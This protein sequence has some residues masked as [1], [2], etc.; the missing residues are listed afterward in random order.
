M[1]GAQTDNPFRPGSGQ[2]PPVLG[3]RVGVLSVIEASFK[4]VASGRYGGANF[5]VAPA[6]MGKTALLSYAASQA[7]QLGW[8][9]LHVFLGSPPPSGT[10]LAEKAPSTL[11]ASRARSGRGAGN[12]IE[13]WFGRV[14]EMAAQRRAGALLTVDDLHG[15]VRGRR[16]A[17]IAPTLDVAAVEGWPLVVLATGLP[18]LTDIIDKYPNLQ[19]SN[20]I[21]LYM[22]S[23]PDSV[24]V[25]Q[26]AAL[27][28][29]RRMEDETARLLARASGGFP[30]ALQMYG[31]AAWEESRG[32]DRIGVESAPVAIRTAASELDRGL[33]GPAWRQCSPRERD[34]LAVVA[35]LRRKGVPA[36]GPD[37]AQKL[38]LTGRELGPARTHLID[39]DLLMTRS[40]ELEFALPGMVDYVL[41]RAQPGAQAETTM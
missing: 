13:A 34:Y 3:G 25:L 20:W 39:N 15:A 40:G 14:A 12:D 28:A 7:E 8:S 17:W 21:P 18:S 30:Y 2:V 23:E 31:F 35:W 41:D 27:A 11:S 32:N 16:S 37:V 24:R 1:A 26:E 9:H 5:F 29:G 4:V 10:L 36:L 19:R 6:G 33:Y 22:F 38:G